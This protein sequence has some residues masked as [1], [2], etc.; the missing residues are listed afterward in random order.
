LDGANNSLERLRNTLYEWGP[1]G[2]ADRTY[3][4]KFTEQINDDLNMPRAL[5]VT[6]DLAR[7]DLDAATKKATL[8]YFDRILGL[9]LDQWQPAQEVIPAE[10]LALVESRQAARSE[11]R[12]ADADAFRQ[13]VSEAGYEIED[14]PQG[15]RV[16]AKKV[17]ALET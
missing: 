10:V 7:S 5:A 3:V 6:W 4:E 1:A 13:Q 16:K 17:Q 11:K 14:T 8:L 9:R 12:W 15:A 2:V